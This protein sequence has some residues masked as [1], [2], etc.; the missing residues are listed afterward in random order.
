[1]DISDQLSEMQNKAL[2]D[3]VRINHLSGKMEINVFELHSLEILV[4][5]IEIYG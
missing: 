5:W 3:I 1:M 4:E 2:H